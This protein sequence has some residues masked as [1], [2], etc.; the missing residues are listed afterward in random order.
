MLIASYV[1]FALF[2]IASVINCYFA[3]VENEKWR[4]ITKPFCLTML[5]IAIILYKPNSP[6]IYLGALFGLA[7]DIFLIW[8]K[9]RWCFVGGILTFL[10]GHIFYL[11]ELIQHIDGNPLSWQVFVVA[12]VVFTVVACCLFPLAKAITKKMPVAICCSIYGPMLITMLVASIYLA[13]HNA[14]HTPGILMTF[15]YLFFIISDSTILFTSFIKK[16]VR[17]PHFYIM[18]TYLIAQALIV[19]GLLLL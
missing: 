13:A 17:R 7:G 15:G 19:A 4:K 5:V 11:V 16:D 6:F 12:A 10:T 8:Q 9:K 2:G 18:A 14:N 1:F 3:F